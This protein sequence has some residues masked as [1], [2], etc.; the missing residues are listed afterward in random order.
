MEAGWGQAGAG[1]GQAGVG[2][3]GLQGMRAGAKPGAMHAQ[4][5]MFEFHSLPHVLARRCSG[6]SSA[7]RRLACL[8][9]RHAGN[10]YA[11][12]RKVSIEQGREL[13]GPPRD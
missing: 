2:G 9:V 6:A 12:R 11:V 5:P 13:A 1:W 10:G 7:Q 4:P 3:S 8:A